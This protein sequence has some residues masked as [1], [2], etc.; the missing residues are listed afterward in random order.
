VLLDLLRWRVLDKLALL[1]EAG[2][3]R[4]TVGNVNAALAV[5][6]MESESISQYVVERFENGVCK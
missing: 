1:V 4:Q 6:H 2:P 5:E 3:L